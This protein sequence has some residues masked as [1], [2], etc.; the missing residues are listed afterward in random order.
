MVFDDY[1]F[2]SFNIFLAASWFKRHVGVPYLIMGENY[3]NTHVKVIHNKYRTRAI[4]ARSRSET[5]L[6]YKPRI[7]G[8]KNEEFPFLVHKVVCNINRTSI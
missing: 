2:W 1:I 3:I 8:L 7:L 6:E 5:T 4:I